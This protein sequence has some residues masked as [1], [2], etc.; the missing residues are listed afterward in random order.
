MGSMDGPNAID[1]IEQ[2]VDCLTLADASGLV[3]AVVET[4]GAQW[5]VY[6]TLLPPVSNEVDESYRFLVGC[7]PELCKLYSKRMWIMNDPFFEY[8]RANTA[9]I[10]GSKV[11]V[12]TSGQAELIKAGA[13]HGFRSMLVVPTHTSMD[14][15]KRMGVLYIGSED[16]IET[17]EPKL[18]RNRVPFGALGTELLLWWSARLRTEAMRK[19]SLRDEDVDLLQLARKGKVACEIAALYD[20]KI[21][22]VYKKL[23][24]IKEKFDVDKIEQAV[25]EAEAHGI[26]T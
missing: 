10:V 14:A 3:K 6:T 1:L 2:L 16:P 4:L 11:K 15:N 12:R 24:N 17:G 22:A 7:S 5:Y 18:L 21:A 13:A 9:P 23:N 26:L 25:K 8:A 20:I 19:F